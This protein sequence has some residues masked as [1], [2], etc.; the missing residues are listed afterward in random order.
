[1]QESS[2]FEFSR[3]FLPLMFLLACGSGVAAL[4]YEI[5]WFQLLEFVIGSSAVSLA[6]ILATFMGGMCLGSLIFPRLV[7]TRQNPL[8]VYAAIEIGI[9]VLGVMVLLLIPLT[10]GVYTAWSGDG[11]RGFLL[12]GIV[13][14]VCLLPPTLLMGTTLPA[15]A[16]GIGRDAATPNGVSWIGFFYGGNIAGAV[17]GCLLA[18]FYLLR[19]H[20]MAT[21]T[22]VAFALNGTVAV[23]ALA[24]AAA[25][26]RY[27]VS[28]DSA[29]KAS[30]GRA[31]GAWA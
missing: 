30:A 29:T 18:G 28:V 7:S 31:A 1:M 2:N 21:A 27:E 20:D 16:R 13:A 24:L 10:N 3:W 17:F 19:V 25:P 6:V 11:L 12:R 26:A 5:V 8:K 22:Y 4:I 9:G 14:A 15:L 23:L